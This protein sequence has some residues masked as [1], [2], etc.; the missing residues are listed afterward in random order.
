MI[1]RLIMTPSREFLG[2]RSVGYRG[3]ETSQRLNVTI[4]LSRCIA[5]W[6][7]QAPDLLIH[8]EVPRNIQLENWEQR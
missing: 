2:A 7:H 6:R 3:N 5:C 4:E 8:S 1:E